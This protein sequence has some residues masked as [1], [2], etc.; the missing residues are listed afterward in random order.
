MSKRAFRS[1]PEVGQPTYPSLSRF[2][3]RQRSALAGLGLGLLSAGPFTCGPGEIA[4]S[5]PMPPS[6]ADAGPELGPEAGPPDGELLADHERADLW[7]AADQRL[8][9]DQRPVKP[10]R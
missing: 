6:L 9:P 7:P 10:G 3:A 4:G 5:P 8:R 1:S 2:L